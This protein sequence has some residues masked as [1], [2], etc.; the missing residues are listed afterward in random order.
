MVLD[1]FKT[2]SLVGTIFSD[3]LTHKFRSRITIAPR[4]N[5]AKMDRE[6]FFPF[7]FASG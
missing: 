7:S 4:F 2:D 1:S 5:P 3:F 6:Q